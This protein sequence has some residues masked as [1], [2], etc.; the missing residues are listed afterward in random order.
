MVQD[1]TDQHIKAILSAYD[2]FGSEVLE[3]GCGGGRITRDLAKHAA[4]VV[5]TDPDPEVVAAAVANVSAE[6]VEFLSPADGIPDVTHKS[7]D[8]AIYT[9]S[10]HH[11]PMQAMQT[12][13]QRVTQLLNDTGVIIVIE[14]GDGGSFNEAR[15][16]FSVDSNDEQQAKAAA[17]YAMQ[18][19]DGWTMSE[20]IYFQTAFL[21]DDED[22]FITNKRPD[23]HLLSKPMQREI[24]A[25]LQKH[26]TTD[27]IL[28]K[29][30]R[31][32][33]LLRKTTGH[34]TNPS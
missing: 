25:F 16:R 8:L 28:L 31:R 21:F 15:E 4:R 34:G 27:G 12:S 19:L 24:G 2:L 1:P 33:N 32:M 6:N 7:F 17:I 13:L 5:A 20:T 10:L 22:D 23:F 26:K 18:N 3:I 14:P 11:V 29:N 9:L 30:K